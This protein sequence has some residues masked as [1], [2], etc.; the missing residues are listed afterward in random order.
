[1]QRIALGTAA[2]V[3]LAGLTSFYYAA[4]SVHATVVN[5]SKARGDQ[6]AYLG[7]AQLIYRN[8]TGANNPPVLQPRN[9]MPLYP[10]FLAA[11]YDPAWTDDEFFVHAR[12]QSIVLSIALLA[13]VAGIAWRS[14]PW[15][16]ALNLSLITA[17]GSF[18]F[19]AGYVQSELLFDTLSFATFVVMW[20]FMR[21][22]STAA[23]VAWAA[24]AG[25]AMALAHLTKAAMLPMVAVFLAVFAGMELIQRSRR[26]HEGVVWRLTAA[27]VLLVTFLGVLYPYIATSK[28]VFGQYFYNLNTTTL[29]WYDDYPDASI[30]LMQYGPEARPSGPPELQPGLRRYLREHTTAVIAARFGHGF[31][32]ML[33]GSYRTFWYLKYVAIYV[34]LAVLLAA[35]AWQAFLDTI[36]RN[37]SLAAFLILYAAVYLPA[38]AFYE[39]ISGTG[40]TR[41]LM[42]HVTPLLFACSAFFA[43]EP[44]RRGSWS[45]AG[46]DITVTH[47]HFAVLVW[48]GLDITFWVWPRAMTTYGGF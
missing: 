30:A 14:L 18:V 41:F 23:S 13:L 43:A 36:R 28:R 25:V 48:I 46:V 34:A 32:D 33:T 11:L 21:E 15:I 4:A 6:S 38:I 2:V 24:L 45:V 20:R 22:R 40:T 17:F 8:W 10:A 31:L 12:I 29:I 9:R 3:L 16:L 42:A 26:V 37:G 1:M 44:F 35:T 7:E 39:P 27:L 5:T 47:V 19:R